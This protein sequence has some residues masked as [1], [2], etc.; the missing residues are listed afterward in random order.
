MSGRFLGDDDVTT[1]RQNG[2]LSLQHAIGTAD[3]LIVEFR[4][5]VVQPTS[6]T[7]PAGHGIDL[8]DRVAGI[9]ENEIGPDHPRQIVSNFLASRKLDQLPGLARV[10]IT[11]NPFRLLSFYAL[12]VK[13]ITGALKNE[14]S[15]SKLFQIGEKFSVDRERVRG[16][17]PVFLC[18]KALFRKRV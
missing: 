1:V 4:I 10:E 13:L 3:D 7:N 8:G 9:S 17:Q 2:F 11:R 18:K 14:E 16:K 5:R 12:L 15:M 6:Q